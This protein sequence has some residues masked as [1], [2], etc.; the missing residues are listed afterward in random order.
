MDSSNGDTSN[1]DD[2]DDRDDM[3]DKDGDKDNEDN[4]DGDTDDEDGDKDDTD[5]TD[6]TDDDFDFGD[7]VVELDR[8]SK[9]SSDVRE[10]KFIIGEL[11][12]HAKKSPPNEKPDPK[13]TNLYFIGLREVLDRGNVDVYWSW[14]YCY[15]AL[16]KC[17]FHPMNKY[18]IVYVKELCQECKK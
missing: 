12:L 15:H 3:S 11:V 6:D 7:L 13:T 1:K 14:S 8:I 9:Q 17:K 4:K 16:R 2:R 18:I 10:I 5:D